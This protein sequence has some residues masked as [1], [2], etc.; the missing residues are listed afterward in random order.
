MLNARYYSENDVSY[1]LYYF[2]IKHENFNG[3]TKHDTQEFCRVILGDS[4]EELYE[5]K[6]PLDYIEKISTDIKS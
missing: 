5:N 1:F 6:P 3:L 4:I 2:S